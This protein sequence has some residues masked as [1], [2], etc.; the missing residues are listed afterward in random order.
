MYTSSLKYVRKAYPCPSI[1]S[2]LIR[3]LFRLFRACSCQA[4]SVGIQWYVDFYS[5]KVNGMYW[6]VRE[7]A[8]WQTTRK[9]AITTTHRKYMDNNGDTV[10]RT[11]TIFILLI[12]AISSVCG[13]IDTT[14]TDA[15]PATNEGTDTE[16]TGITW[17][18][19]DEGM[20]IAQEQN[21]PVMIDVY[22]NWCT[23]CKELDRVVYI[24]PDVIKLSDEFVCIKIDAD[25][26]R[27][28]AAKY[29]PRGSVPI[30]I[31]LRADDTEVHR[32]AGYPRAGASAFA[33]EMRVALGKV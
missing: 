15:P 3:R 31:F 25:Q 27:D 33:Q 12:L 24:D 10:N 14:P 6:C 19:Y 5:D 22:T 28:L 21:K 13:C 20:R 8:Y 18:S 23:W 4:P 16:G 32:L 29:N 30:V 2:I 7:N 11:K 17:Y 1:H 26:Q 9:S